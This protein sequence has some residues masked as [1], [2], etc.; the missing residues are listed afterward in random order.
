MIGA[1]IA[2]LT[3]ARVLA[4][5]FSRVVLIDRDRLPNTAMVRRGVPQGSHGHILLVAGQQ[6]LEDLFPGLLSELVQAGAVPFDPILD[7]SVYQNGAIW[8]QAASRL[9]LVTFTRPLLETTLL[10]RVRDVP[11]VQ[12]R[13][14][15]AVAGLTGAG[16]R[17]TGVKLDNG[18]TISSELVVDCSGR[19]TRSDRWLAGLGL[20]AP[21]TEEVK[22]DVGYATRLFRRRPGDLDATA[23]FV[24]PSAPHQ[25]RAGL[26]LPVEGDRWLVSVGG[27]HGEFPTGGERAF[28]DHARS[29]PH[30]A[31]ATVLK[32]CEPVT[33]IVT[34]RFPSSRFRRFEELDRVPAGYLALGDAFCSFNPIYGQG[35]TCAAMQATALGGLLDQHPTLDATLSRDFYRAAAR[36]LAT[37]WQLAAGGDFAYP[38]TKGKRP[39]GIRLSTSYSRQIQLA[40]QVDV[41]VRRIFTSVQH[42]IVPPA[43]LRRPKTVWR[44][45]R[46]A[47]RAPGARAGRSGGPS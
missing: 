31:I 16:D 32:R 10:R 12:I 22:V 44:V 47:R 23:V 41:E 17:I 34:H 11:N 26:V 24:L 4:D 7:L 35:M 37:P 19:G 42:M 9:R 21:R 6:I 46:A 2:G 40:A 39:R 33:D 38:E 25:K 45:L 13:D 15:V 28:H 29:L 18:E 1:G 14:A 36:I 30:P 20:P 5:R 43:V 3:A 27:W 8:P